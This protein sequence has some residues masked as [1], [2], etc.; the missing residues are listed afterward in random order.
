[1]I[2][3][4]YVKNRPKG[5]WHLFS[6]TISAEAANYD[7]NIALKQAKLAGN[8]NAEVGIKVFDSNFYIPELLTEIKEQKPMFN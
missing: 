6:T 8:D 1:M 3:G 7:S 5:K 2:H 4:I